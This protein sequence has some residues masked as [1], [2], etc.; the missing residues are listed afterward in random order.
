MLF[1]SASLEH[2]LKDIAAA[3][4]KLVA[5]LDDFAVIRSPVA[6]VAF[7]LSARPAPPIAEVAEDDLAAI[8]YTSGTT[9]R[10]KGVLLSH[11]N[12]CYNAHKSRT[13]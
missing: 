7:A 13:I 10:P 8:I 11:G 3:L 4:P 2:R 12:I 1:V 5:R 9:G 6:G